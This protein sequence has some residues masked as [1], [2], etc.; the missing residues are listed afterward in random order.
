MHER[1]ARVSRQGIECSS[2]NLVA[3]PPALGLGQ[4]A[5]RTIERR[6]ARIDRHNATVM[7]AD[8]D[9]HVILGATATWNPPAN[10]APNPTPRACNA[11][12]FLFV[13]LRAGL[14]LRGW[15]DAAHRS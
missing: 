13:G 6:L 9:Q 11:G 14:Q 8:R 12:T 10:R 3:V 5:M 1:P 7:D 4:V 15:A 2:S